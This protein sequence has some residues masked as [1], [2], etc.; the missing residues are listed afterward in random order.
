MKR[1]IAFCLVLL[2]L[3]AC[4]QDKS[5]KSVLGRSNA[6][7]ELEQALTNH[8]QHNVVDGTA[9][10]KN[11]STAVHVAEPILFGIY[12]KDNILDQRPYDVHLV[13]HHWIISGTLPEGYHGG[14]F[15]I[16][17]DS[18]NAK[19]VKLTHGK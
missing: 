15:L 13:K 19:V 14:T 11:R 6:E 18:R 5:N 12:G 10:I 1:I 3:S 9:I 4:G 17:I 16:I 7:R 2:F 8:P